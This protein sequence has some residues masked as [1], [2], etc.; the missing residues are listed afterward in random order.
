MKQHDKLEE[1]T[2]ELLPVRTPSVS[3]R[4]EA[5]KAWYSSL[6]SKKYRRKIA[7][8]K[9]EAEAKFWQ[10]YEDLNLDLFQ[11]SGIFPRRGEVRL[12][13]SD[14]GKE[15][16]VNIFRLYIPSRAGLSGTYKFRDDL[17]ELEVTYSAAVKNLSL[18]GCYWFGIDDLLLM[19]EFPILR[20]TTRTTLQG[21]FPNFVPYWK[22]N[23]LKV[24][25]LRSG[26][27][28][29][30]YSCRYVYA[31]SLQGLYHAFVKMGLIEEVLKD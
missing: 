31:D 3:S 23:D 27:C 4:A 20:E 11:T 28:F 14:T 15:V 13:Q 7:Q 22:N 6:M 17:P 2:Y 29:Q 26:Q 19:T 18:H 1:P 16:C 24:R 12:V 21:P 30:V 9:A 8:K 10:K 25:I 5:W